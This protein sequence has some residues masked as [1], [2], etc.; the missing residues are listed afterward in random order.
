LTGKNVT[1]KMPGGS[2][3]ITLLDNGHVMMAGPATFSFRGTVEVEL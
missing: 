3:T 1:V 2:L